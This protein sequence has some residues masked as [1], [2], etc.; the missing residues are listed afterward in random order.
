MTAKRDL[1][2][3]RRELWSL[4]W[5]ADETMISLSCRSRE[6]ALQTAFE[7]RG[8]R[9]FPTYIEG[10]HGKRVDPHQGL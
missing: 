2:R 8:E 7:L 10:P 6:E 5:L 1:Y 9:G 3:S 4:V